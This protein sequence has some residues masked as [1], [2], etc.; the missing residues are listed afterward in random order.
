[1]AI[2]V[3]NFFKEKKARQFILSAMKQDM[4]EKTV[5]EKR[6]S[7]YFEKTLGLDNH[8]AVSKI[9]RGR[10]LIKDAGLNIA[11]TC[12]IGDTLHDFEVAEE[13]GI[14]C[15]LIADGHQSKKRLQ[16]SGA[17][18]LNSIGDLLNIFEG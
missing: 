16:K 6:I 3:L 1:L 4:L 15:I 11:N 13:L 17:T 5:S 14:Q 7:N 2:N 10:Q 12:I 9:E 8:Y 18:V